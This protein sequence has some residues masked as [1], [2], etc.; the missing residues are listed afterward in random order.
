MTPLV[1]LMTSPGDSSTVDGIVWGTQ[2]RAL[3]HKFSFWPAGHRVDETDCPLG[4]GNRG[5]R[6]QVNDGEAGLP[7][8]PEM[9]FMSSH[10]K[11]LQAIY[12]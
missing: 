2:A 12:V 11:E 5:L 4:T 8:Y 6:G 9:R 7:W 10:R 1:A 3:D